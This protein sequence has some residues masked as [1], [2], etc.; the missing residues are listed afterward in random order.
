VKQLEKVSADYFA[1]A[2]DPETLDI[3]VAVKPGKR[4]RVW[5]V[6]SRR[7]STKELEPLRKKLEA[8]PAL[9]VFGGPVAFAISGAVVGG[10]G[11][12]GNASK[13]GPPLPKEWTDA[14]A[15]EKGSIE[16]PEGFLR[17]VW[18]D[19]SVAAPKD[20]PAPE[21]FV[22]QVLEPT[23][24]R[25]FRPKDWHY[26]EGHRGPVYLWT[27]SEEDTT[28]DGNYT[29]GVRI[30]MFAE[31]KKGTGKT[32]KEF[33]VDFMESKVKE[34]TRVIER[35]E[36][37]EVGLFKRVCLEVEEG[38][39][40]ILYSMSWGAND[41]DIAVI[42]IAGTKKELWEKYAPTFSRMKEFELIDMKRFEK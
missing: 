29:T 21:G 24:G 22:N 19:E 26:M 39:H 33:I 28:K 15:K 40:H 42:T 4:S 23:G 16:V 6:S 25:I 30:Q 5:F 1:A 31:V 10:D 11:K 7:K 38:P 14:A 41:L 20:I 3:V 32:A 8:V 27:I 13:E 17:L 12:A 9:A 35:C 34:A 36:E 37:K 18:P 2:K